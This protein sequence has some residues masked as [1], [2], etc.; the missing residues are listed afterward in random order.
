MDLM[1]LGGLICGVGVVYFVL[2]VGQMTQ[3]LLNREAFLLI[4]GGTLGS[5]MISYPWSSLRHVP[6]GLRMILFP[7]KRPDALIIIRALVDLAGKAR[8]EGVDSLAEELPLLPHPY[9]ADCIHM[10][11]DGLEPEVLRERCEQDILAA[12]QRHQQVSGVFRSAGTFAPIF[13]LLGTLIGVVQVLRHITDPAAMGRS[14]AVAMSASFYGIF[15]ANFL[16]LPIATKL[17]Y[18]SD[19]DMLAREIIIKGT[20]SLQKGESPWLMARKLESFLA[21][22]LRRQA[23]A[24]LKTPA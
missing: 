14:M 5:I 13:G 11:L 17:N 16:F 9:L 18:Y 4:F 7:P 20:L 8:R 21:F 23:G 22:N 15:S 12:Q 10:L 1:T 6:T 3:F 24:G 2:Y 19:E